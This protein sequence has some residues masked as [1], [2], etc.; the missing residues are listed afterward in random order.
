[1]SVASGCHIVI[2]TCASSGSLENPPRPSPATERGTEDLAG[3]RPVVPLALDLGLGD[4]L[5]NDV[6]QGR[7][8]DQGKEIVRGAQ[9]SLGR[10]VPGRPSTFVARFWRLF[11]APVCRRS[12][13]QWGGALREA[14]ADTSHRRLAA[15]LP[16]TLGVATITDKGTVCYEMP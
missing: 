7:G 13:F 1:M 8:L 16:M 6:S 12:F 3:A 14:M 10:L 4:E 9:G 11:S 5:G 2:W 15:L